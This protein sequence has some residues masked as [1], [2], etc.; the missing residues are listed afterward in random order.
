M[1][2]TRLGNR[3]GLIPHFLEGDSWVTNEAAE[4]YTV[5]LCDRGC[6][7]KGPG[8][9]REPDSDHRPLEGAMCP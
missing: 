1:S 4:K 5:A 2:R 9:N 7:G 3:A 6:Q 8:E